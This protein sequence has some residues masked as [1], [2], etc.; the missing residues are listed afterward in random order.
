MLK[1]FEQDCVDSEMSKNEN[2][3][4]MKSFSNDSYYV[5]S[6]IKQMSR[7]H[8]KDFMEGIRRNITCCNYQRGNSVGNMKFI[9]K[10]KDKKHEDNKLV[11]I[12]SCE[13]NV[14][15]FTTRY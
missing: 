12:A 2:I 5:G 14:L 7:K 9:F 15:K 8:K 1:E 6:T 11:G 3:P 13:E 4:K 10:V